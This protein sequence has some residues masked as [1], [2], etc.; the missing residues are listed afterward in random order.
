[1]QTNCTNCGAALS[2]DH[3]QDRLQCNYCET[4]HVP[5]L[6][7]DAQ[8][9]KLE[10]IGSATDCPVCFTELQHAKIDRWHF[11]YCPGCHGLLFD[12][13]AFLNV[14][15]YLRQSATEPF[16]EPEPI[17][18]RDL[19]RKIRCPDCKNTMSVHPYYGPGNFVID[20]CNQCDHV[21]LD[22]GDLHKTTQT[23]WGG[24]LWQ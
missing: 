1:M 11:L 10:G 2:L 9:Q 20:T 14:V 19:D 23:K 16:N 8:V 22:G 21:W 7:E 12:S 24:S 4:V 18:P 13:K 6:R 5:S 3:Y 15:L 17:D